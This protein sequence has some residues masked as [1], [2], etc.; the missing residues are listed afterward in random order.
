[1]LEINARS[2]LMIKHV[3]THYS[4]DHCPIRVNIEHNKMNWKVE[5]R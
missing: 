1:M 3:S 4:E 5:K 2:A